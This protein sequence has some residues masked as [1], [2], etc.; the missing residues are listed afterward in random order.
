MKLCACRKIKIDIFVASHFVCISI[1][2]LTKTLEVIKTIT[3][4]KCG[5]DWD[6]L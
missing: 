4:L 1:K 6:N 2:I 3:I 5:G